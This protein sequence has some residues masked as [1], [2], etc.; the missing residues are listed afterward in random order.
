MLQV[1]IQ[2]KYVTHPLN[3]DE[4]GISVGRKVVLFFGLMWSTNR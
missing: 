2:E 1:K 3:K 4:L